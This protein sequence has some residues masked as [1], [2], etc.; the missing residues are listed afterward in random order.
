MVFDI[1]ITIFFTAIVQ[2]ILGTG[3]L[4]FGTPILLI[5]GYDFQ[6]A[7]I[8]LLPTSI[9]INFFQLKNGSKAE[10]PFTDNEYEVR[11][12]GLRGIIS[13][14]NLY[15]CLMF[16]KISDLS[17]P[18]LQIP[19]NPSQSLIIAPVQKSEKSKLFE[20]TF[21]E[22]TILSCFSA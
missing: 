3:V 22:N 17:T 14:N 5:L 15:L 12:K 6:Y 4:L 1:L 21:S 11:L 2:S 20:N 7:L 8:I 9:L 16:L 13:K 18:T 10:L 19:I